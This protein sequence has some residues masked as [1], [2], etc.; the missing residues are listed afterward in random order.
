MTPKK[1][2]PPGQAKPKPEPPEPK[3]KQPNPKSPEARTEMLMAAIIYAGRDAD[4]DFGEAVAAAKSI[5]D[6][7]LVQTAE[8]LGLDDEIDEDDIDTGD[9][10]G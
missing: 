1:S 3:P 6:E 4:I 5:R 8:E 2:I 7:W 9:L 10:E